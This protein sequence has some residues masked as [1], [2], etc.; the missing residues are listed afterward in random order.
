M[1]NY[2]GR[3]LRFFLTDFR[4]PVCV[5]RQ[6]VYIGNHRR[7]G[8]GQMFIRIVSTPPLCDSPGEQL[9]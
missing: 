2:D 8:I 7:C 9:E 3:S 4:H 6:N 1:R 5:Y